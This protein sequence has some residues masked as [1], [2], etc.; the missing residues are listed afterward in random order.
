MEKLFWH[1]KVQINLVAFYARRVQKYELVGPWRHDLDI[2]EKLRAPK[3][4]AST[5]H[6]SSTSS[7]SSS[8]NFSSSAPQSN[9][10]EDEVAASDGESTYEVTFLGK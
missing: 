7:S 4:D 2:K 9:N 6:L 5:S 8:S 3:P 1:M 10:V